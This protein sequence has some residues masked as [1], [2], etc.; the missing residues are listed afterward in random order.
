MGLY[1]AALVVGLAGCAS[2]PAPPERPITYD[3]G[4][5]AV[6]PLDSDRSAPLP[7]VALASVEGQGPLEGSTAMFYRLDYAD[8]RQ[9]QPYAQ[10]RWSVPPTQ[11]VRQALAARLG[12]RRPVLAA[13]E[14]VLLSSYDDGSL[15]LVVRVELEEFSQIFTSAADSMGLVRL[16]VTLVDRT[17]AGDKLLGQRMVVVQRPAPTPDAAGGVRALASATD[18]AAQDVARWLEQ[19]RR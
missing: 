5:G 1:L 15:P 2:L 14:S 16:R 12:Q 4:A 17:S 6:K 9:T 3:F 10:A 8:A 11:L 7:A 18:Q 13:S 19:V